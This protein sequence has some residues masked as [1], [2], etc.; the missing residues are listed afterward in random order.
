VSDRNGAVAKAVPDLF[1]R[2]L[3]LA[4]DLL[5]TLP[6]SLPCIANCTSKVP[7]GPADRFL[8][9]PERRYRDRDCGQ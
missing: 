7:R 3:R 9:A 4:T 2:A 8:R 1:G 5:G 6:D